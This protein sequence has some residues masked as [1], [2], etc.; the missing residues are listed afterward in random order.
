MLEKI[1]LDYLNARSELP[2][3][4]TER[5]GQ[6]GECIV[7]EKV[8]GSETNH[9][10]RSSLAVQSYADSMFRAAEINELVIAA[11]KEIIE[12]PKISRCHLDSNYN[13]T[14]TQTKKY[15]YQAVFDLYHY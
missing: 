4:V 15:R 7:I 14:D 12:L 6:K 13:Y 2:P 1:V 3:T 8:G 11:M 9:I 10:K 5:N